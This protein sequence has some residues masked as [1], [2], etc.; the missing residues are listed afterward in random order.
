PLHNW[1]SNGADAFRYMA[2]VA[3]KSKGQSAEVHM[4]RPSRLSPEDLAPKLT[5]DGLYADRETLS[6][7]RRARRI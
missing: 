6:M 1:A 5:L 4:N 3:Q 2:L 7:G